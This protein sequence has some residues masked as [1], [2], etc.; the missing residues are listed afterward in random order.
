MQ[1]KDPPPLLVGI[2]IRMS[3]ESDC[4]GSA[5]D[6]WCPDTT[7]CQRAWEEICEAKLLEIVGSNASGLG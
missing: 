6:Q 7:R 4:I 2:K 5:E 3:N 1:I